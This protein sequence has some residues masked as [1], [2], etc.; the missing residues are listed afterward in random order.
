MVT[1]GSSLQRK[2][3]LDEAAVY[4]QQ[5]LDLYQDISDFA[6]QVEAGGELGLCYLR[7]G[8]L[9]GALVLLEQTHQVMTTHGLVGHQAVACLVGLAEAYLAAAEQSTPNNLNWLKK[10]IPLCKAALKQSKTCR[11]WLPPALRTLG[12]Y[13]WLKGNPGKAQKTWQSS[14]EA[15]QKIGEQYELGLTH[16]EIGIRLN[17]QN[18]LERADALFTATGAKSHRNVPTL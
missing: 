13:Y 2:G 4:L 3:N 17:L 1:L 7:Q 11:V 18:H 16:L 6:G 12:T 8:N 14:L 5:T 9:E 10:A 15:A